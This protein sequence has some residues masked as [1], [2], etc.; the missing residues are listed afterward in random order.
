MVLSIVANNKERQKINR[1]NP[2]DDQTKTKGAMLWNMQNIQTNAL[3]LQWIRSFMSIT[4]GIMMGI[5][6]LTGLYGFIG[7][8][9][10]HIVVSVGILFKAGFNLTDYLP[11]TKL[12]GFL[13]DG[14]MGELMSFLLFW[15]L[16]YALVHV[17]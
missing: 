17:Y 16:F 3:T 11:G 12:P 13:I 2:T 5:L 8:A 7:F 6:G 14:L 1:M 10:L 9:L 15:V 4:S